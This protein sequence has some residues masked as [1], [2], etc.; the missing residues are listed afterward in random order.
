[1]DLEGSESGWPGKMPFSSEVLF[2]VWKPEGARWHFTGLP[3]SL[4][5]GVWTLS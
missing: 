4:G 2:L 1:M 3:R 5:E